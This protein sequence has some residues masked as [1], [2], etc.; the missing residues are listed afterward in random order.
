M[1]FREAYGRKA[2]GRE[3]DNA[4]TGSQAMERHSSVFRM[5]DGESRLPNATRGRRRPE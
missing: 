2:D 5:N 3:M 1:E 4:V